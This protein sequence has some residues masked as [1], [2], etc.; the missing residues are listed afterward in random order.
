[1]AERPGADP[2]QGL[3]DQQDPA[4]GQTIGEDAAGEREDDRRDA[5]R[6]RHRGHGGGAAGRLV[7]EIAE[8]DDLH[9]GAE[10]RRPLRRPVPA[11]RP[12]AQRR[13]RPAAFRERGRIRRRRHSPT[14]CARSST[15]AG[16]R[17]SGRRRRHP[18]PLRGRRS[19]ARSRNPAGRG[20]DTIAPASPRRRCDGATATP[21]TSV[22]P[23]AAGPDWAAPTMCRASASLAIN[24]CPPRLSDAAQPGDGALVGGFRVVED[25]VLEA[26]HLEQRCVV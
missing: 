21:T 2:E 14:T 11:E 20:V 5:V 15:S 18:G 22:A 7:D 1:M 24:A 3:G 19:Q 10:Q 12:H 26:R 4:T 17:R 23:P 6:R 25:V 8:G 13:R 9:P 16:T